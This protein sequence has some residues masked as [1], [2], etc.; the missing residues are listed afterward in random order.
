MNEK[1]RGSY[2]GGETPKIGDTIKLVKHHDDSEQA[3]KLGDVC[4]VSR[5]VIMDNR[6]DVYVGRTCFGGFWWTCAKC[7]E[8][9]NRREPFK[10]CTIR[11]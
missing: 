10:G 5:Y 8:L 6:W 2:I 9:V 11:D 4:V 1:M 3:L 7:W